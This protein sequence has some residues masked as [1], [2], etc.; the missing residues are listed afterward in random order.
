MLACGATRALRERVRVRAVGTRED[1]VIFATPLYPHPR[2]LSQR[3][4]RDFANGPFLPFLVRSPINHY[5]ELSRD[6]SGLTEAGAPLWSSIMFVLPMHQFG[7]PILR[8]LGADHY[9]CR[10]RVQP[11]S[12]SL[13]EAA[14]DHTTRRLGAHLR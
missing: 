9:R 3:E 2:P 10:P 14:A 11:R 1:V 6:G 8:P 12:V 13:V 7:E 4:R 5:D